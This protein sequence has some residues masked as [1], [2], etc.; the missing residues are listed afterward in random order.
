MKYKDNKKFVELKNARYP[1]LRIKCQKGPHSFIDTFY[2][3]NASNYGD[4]EAYYK[5]K[6]LSIFHTLGLLH[7]DF[8]KIFFVKLTRRKGRSSRVV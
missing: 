8:A 1:I 3:E 6:I 5:T 7:G 2:W 4:R